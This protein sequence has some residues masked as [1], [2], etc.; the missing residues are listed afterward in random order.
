MRKTLMT[1]VLILASGGAQAE[2]DRTGFA[3]QAFGGTAWNASTTLKID[4]AGQPPL[5]FDA[6]WDTKPFKQPLYW[7]LRARWRRPDDGFELQLLHHKVILAN[8]QQGVEHFEVTH[9]FNTLTVHY[10]KTVGWLDGRV[11]AGAVIPHS[12][13]TIRGLHHDPAGY[14]IAGPAVIA[15][16]GTEHVF[17]SRILLAAE[18][19]FMAGWANVG[20]AGGT[21]DVTSVGLHLLVGVGYVF[22]GGSGP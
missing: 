5:E 6:E 13:S 8:P 14:T 16:V 10:V 21:A 4:Q 19:Q 12:D 7:A 2:A 3:F 22:G 9:G 20:V 17:D 15:G 11:G 18:V 1:L